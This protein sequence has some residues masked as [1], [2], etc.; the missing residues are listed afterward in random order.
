[1]PRFADE[2]GAVLSEDDRE[3]QQ[4]DQMCRGFL[5][6]GQALPLRRLLQ[7][8]EYEQAPNVMVLYA[9][10]FSITNY[11]VA[12]GG[13]QAFL[14]FVGVGMRGNW[15]QAVQ[16]YYHL[17]SVEALEEQ[18]LTHLRNTK[19]GG[20][21]ALAQ[22]SQPGRTNAELA[23]RVVTRQTAPPAQ[24]LLDGGSTAR[25]QSPEDD[26]RTAGRPTHLPDRVPPPP[27]PVRPAP[28]PPAL[29]PVRLGLPEFGP[30]GPAGGVGQG[31]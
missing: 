1:V 27:P 30:A 26:S 9:E 15:D 6:K 10:G 3:R 19:N 21:A 12:Q 23:G 16:T 24:P 17:P 2:G 7:L 22:N 5:N 28:P 4:H 25:G 14:G 20:S 8:R 31:N 29:P 11:L 13:R 18:W